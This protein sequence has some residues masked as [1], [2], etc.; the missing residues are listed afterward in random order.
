MR[1]IQIKRLD[2]RNVELEKEIIDVE[3]RLVDAEARVGYKDGRIREL[4][5]KV[6][7]LEKIRKDIISTV[8]ADMPLMMEDASARKERNLPYTAAANVTSNRTLTLGGADSHQ[9]FAG[10]DGKSY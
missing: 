1:A 10:R 6:E 4:E 9:T 2:K 3:S 7:S 8:G 5:S